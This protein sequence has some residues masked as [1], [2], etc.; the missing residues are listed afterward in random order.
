[1]RE[2]GVVPPAGA[3]AVEGPG[4]E[5]AVAGTGGTAGGR[6]GAGAVVGADIVGM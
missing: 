3:E 4:A 2:E 6:T 1:M 5:A